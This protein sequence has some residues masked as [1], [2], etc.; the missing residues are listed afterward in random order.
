MLHRASDFNIGVCW[1]ELS[2]WN[3]PKASSPHTPPP[4]KLSKYESGMIANCVGVVCLLYSFVLHET[5]NIFVFVC[6][7]LVHCLC[8]LHQI[9]H[10]IH[11]L[12]IIVYFVYEFW[13]VIF[14]VYKFDYLKKKSIF[15]NLLGILR[16]KKDKILYQKKFQ[17]IHK[18][19]LSG[20][21]NNYWWWPQLQKYKFW[22]NSCNSF[23]MCKICAV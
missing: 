10:F 23:D 21:S 9:N 11:K 15:V 5:L 14:D 20:H 22:K 1:Y 18:Q 7:S 17:C 3:M 12:F 4:K 6:Q 8:S 19:T 16:V 13:L 2:L